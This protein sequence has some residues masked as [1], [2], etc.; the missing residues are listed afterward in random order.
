[1]LSLYIFALFIMFSF[2]LFIPFR[3]FGLA[4]KYF[5]RNH[6][7]SIPSHTHLGMKYVSVAHFPMQQHRS[8]SVCFALSNIHSILLGWLLDGTM[9]VV[10]FFVLWFC[11]CFYSYAYCIYHQFWLAVCRIVHVSMMWRVFIICSITATV[12]PFTEHTYVQTHVPIPFHMHTILFLC[13]GIPD[14][15]FEHTHIPHNKCPDDALKS[16][17]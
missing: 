12:R 5:K 10:G 1:M 2:K 3:A 13:Y 15:L 4:A 6:L 7:M 11:F 9:F 8:N 17:Y 14:G 16:I